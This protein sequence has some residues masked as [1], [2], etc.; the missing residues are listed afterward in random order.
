M[1]EYDLVSQRDRPDFTTRDLWRSRRWAK[2]RGNEKFC[3]F[4]PVGLKE[5]F[6]V[7]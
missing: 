4:I 3:L 1:G 2:E 5:F 7:P 6:Y